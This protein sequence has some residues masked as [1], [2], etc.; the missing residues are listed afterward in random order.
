MYLCNV[1]QLINILWGLILSISASAQSE[2]FAITLKVDSAIASEPQKVYLYSQIENQMQLHDSLSIDS[3]HRVG[4]MHGKVPYEYNVNILFTRR[5]PQMVPVVANGG[6]S[7]SIHVGDEDDGFRLR[8]IDKVEGSP[9]TLEMVHYNQKYDSLHSEYLRLFNKMQVYNLSD[10]KRDSIKK[11][12]D[13]AV[14]RQMRYR[15]DYANMGKSPY[16]V[17]GVADDVFYSHRLNPSMSPYTEDEVDA[18]MNSLLKRFPDYPPMKAF[19]NDSTLGSYTSAESF[20]IW[21]QFQLRRYSNRF[22]V[23]ND[24]SIV[25][26]L[27]VG[28][29]MNLQFYGPGSANVNELRGKYV[30]VDF[31]ASW[32]QPCMAQM[33]NIRLAAE[34]FNED[35]VVCMIGM[36]ENRKQ[37]W[38]TI[39]EMDMRNK[40]L[41]QTDLPYQ[42]QHYRVYD[43]KTGKMYASYHRLGIKTIPHNYLVDRSGRIIAKN[44]SITLAIDRLNELLEKEKQR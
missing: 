14:V 7:I 40:D 24:D 38:S 2:R 42:I 36:D 37:W 13:Q 12:A 11:L 31:W 8:Y 6:D 34:M 35:L 19:V 41:T 5:G 39:K 25:K 10:E 27:K 32:C 9:S 22:Q 29:Y 16:C 18:M 28:D 17:I 1:K 23:E 33:E 3:V 30:L 43:D 26:P 44:I 15:L 21:Q 20:A 4:T